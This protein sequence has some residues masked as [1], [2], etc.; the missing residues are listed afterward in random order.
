MVLQFPSYQVPSEGSA[1]SPKAPALLPS[2]CVDPAGD[3]VVYTAIADVLG[4]KPQTLRDEAS[5]PSR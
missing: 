2:E 3:G 5:H 1:A 4:A